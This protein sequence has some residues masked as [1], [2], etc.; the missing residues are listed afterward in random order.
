MLT[1]TALLYPE[2]FASG[3]YFLLIFRNS[4]CSYYRTAI[5]WTRSLYF[6][7]KVNTYPQTHSYLARGNK[8][9]SG[10]DDT[11]EPA[12]QSAGRV[13]HHVAHNKFIHPDVP[14]LYIYVHSTQNK[15][16]IHILGY[17]ISCG[18][19]QLVKQQQYSSFFVVLITGNVVLHNFGVNVVPTK[20]E[21]PSACCCVVQ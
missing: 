1:L 15:G 17:D 8:L 21:H 4:R 9:T 20:K 12:R 6:Q 7:L 16:R 18:N 19:V 13:C 5:K 3:S 11:A 14:L 2:F 10:P